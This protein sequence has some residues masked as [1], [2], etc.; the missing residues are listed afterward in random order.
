MDEIKAILNNPCAFAYLDPPY[1]YELMNSKDNY[2]HNMDKQQQIK[3]LSLI[4]KATSAS[5]W[6]SVK[7]RMLI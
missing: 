7:I 3:F 6:L 4:Q 1:D 2:R 5:K